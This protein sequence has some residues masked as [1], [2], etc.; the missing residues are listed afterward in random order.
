MKNVDVI[1]NNMFLISGSTEIKDMLG[2]F[3]Q[4]IASSRYRRSG[5]PSFEVVPSA[6]TNTNT[7]ANTNTNIL[8]EHETMGEI[9]PQKERG[10]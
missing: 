5:W 1:S 2:A 3:S 9:Q 7:N 4:T 10:C 6:N 8:Q